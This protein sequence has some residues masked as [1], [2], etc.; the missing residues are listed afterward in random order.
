MSESPNKF[1][2]PIDIEEFERRIH[3]PGDHDDSAVDPLEELA[4]LVDA[5]SPPPRLSPAPAPARASEPAA[6]A[7]S[8]FRR[9]LAPVA[10]PKPPATESWDTELEDWEEQLRGLS[11]PVAPA[12]VETRRPAQAWTPVAAP[13]TPAPATTDFNDFDD[14]TDEASS[15]F[16]PVHQAGHASEVRQ[17]ADEKSR[18]SYHAGTEAGEA[19]PY[20]RPWRREADAEAAQDYQSSDA[21]PNRRKPLLFAGVGVI[22]F[23]A[24]AGGGWALMSAAGVRKTPPTIL[25]SGD[26]AKVQPATAVADQG[27]APAGGI[28]DRRGDAIASSKVVNN[29]EQPVDLRAPI[30]PPSSD[31][32]GSGTAQPST[33]PGGGYFPTPK[34][35]KT[36]PVRPDGS[37]IEP[38]APPPRVAAPSTPT[39]VE[40]PVAQSTATPK[41]AA[42][43][44]TTRVA[45]AAKNDNA[46]TDTEV[47][48]ATPHAKPAPVAP[49]VAKPARVATSEP[50]GSIG[51]GF[52]VQFAAAGSDAE[53][54]DRV[55]KV[56]SQFGS[57][58]GGRKAGVVRGEANGNTVYRVRVSGLSKDSA[59]ALCG[60]VKEN[61]GTC[62]V[63][64]N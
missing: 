35:V 1:R 9:P 48:P 63:A 41:V 50:V 39:H 22:G 2:P 40:S 51:G 16:Q 31:V 49:P 52:A 13:P 33:S 62:F 43:K 64:G 25:A 56:Q 46:R 30:A 14:F 24:L 23:L 57:A 18:E 21:A 27:G 60:K 55:N 12:P 53:A 47:A 59:V 17:G 61:G 6:V 26:P 37:L 42:P 3:A 38:D 32:S 29:Q 15:P 8:P 7:A 34:R 5:G 45:V 4:R 11:A 19:D 20:P 28:F 36:V 58:L 44:T 10:A 54:R